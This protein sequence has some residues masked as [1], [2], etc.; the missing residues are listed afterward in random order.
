VAVDPTGVITGFGFCAASAADQQAAETFF[1]MRHRPNPRLPSVGS[2]FYS[3]LYVADKDFEGEEH[4]RRWLQCYG[5]RIIHP[6]KRN[7]LKRSWP[8]GLRRWVAGIRQI[9]ESVYDKLFNTFGMWRER[10]H[11]LEGLR[12]RLAAR[13]A[14]HNF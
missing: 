8:K 2:A 12:A 11:E 5:V 14:L 3:G 13:V 10:P 7:S 9:I 1:A 4:H 6:P